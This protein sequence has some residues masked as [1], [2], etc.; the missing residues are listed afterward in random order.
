MEQDTSAIKSF[1]DQILAGI[2]RELP[3]PK[4]YDYDVNHAPKRK[5]ILSVDEK[6]LAVKNAL[7][8][9]EPRHHKILAPEFAKEL[10]QFGRIYMY[11]FRRLGNRGAKRTHF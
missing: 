5:D 6:K 9:F 4:P 7:R 3:Q 2:P 10:K 1:N 8:Y 11:R